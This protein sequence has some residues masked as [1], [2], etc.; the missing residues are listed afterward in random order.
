MEYL[1]FVWV[2]TVLITFLF[3]NMKKNVLE[4]QFFKGLHGHGEEFLLDLV[5]GTTVRHIL[6]GRGNPQI[7]FCAMRGHEYGYPC[8]WTLS[9]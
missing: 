6:H 9:L 5:R 2:F 7:L 4:L 1:R 3:C 8:P